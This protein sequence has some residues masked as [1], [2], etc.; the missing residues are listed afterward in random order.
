MDQVSVSAL[1]TL[2]RHLRVLCCLGDSDKSL[3]WGVAS[4]LA[5]AGRSVAR[6]SQ[7]E[8]VISGRSRVLSKMGG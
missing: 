5:S 7:S 2:L 4:G 8:R 1:D 6:V 3:L